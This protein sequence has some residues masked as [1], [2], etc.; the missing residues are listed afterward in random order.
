MNIEELRIKNPAFGILNI[1]TENFLLFNSIELKTKRG[2]IYAIINLINGKVYVGQS[3]SNFHDRYKCDWVRQTDNDHLRKAAKKYGRENFRALLLEEGRG[4]NILNILETYYILKFKSN[5]NEFGYNK[6]TGGNNEYRL[7]EDT[8]NKLRYSKQEFVELAI[9]KHGNKYNYDLVEYKTGLT[10]VKIFCNA[11]QTVFGQTPSSHLAGKGCKKCG[12]R[13][14]AQKSLISFEEFLAR[15]ELKFGN[16]YTFYKDSYTR[17][18][19]GIVI[20][21]HNE[22]GAEFTNNPRNLLNGSILCPVC[23]KEYCINKGKI[24][25]SYVNGKNI[26]KWKLKKGFD[27]YIQKVKNI[28]GNKI[29][30]LEYTSEPFKNNRN[31]LKVKHKCND[32]DKEFWRIRTDIKSNCPFCNNIS[33]K[34]KGCISVSPTTI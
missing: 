33:L 22:C 29:I 2:I 14:M 1:K 17:F 4:I 10:K 34:E 23:Y 7:N 27:S 5:E 26:S 21:K 3:I 6:T 9:K 8:I 19:D 30:C 12:L 13:A 20:G 18:Y 25:R 31:I 15:A 24:L 28:H 32:C 16:E 11:C